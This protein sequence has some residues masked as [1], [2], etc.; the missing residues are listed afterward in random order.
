MISGGEGGVVFEFCGLELLEK[1][2]QEVG[3]ISLFGR[4]GSFL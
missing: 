4:R 1:G 2:D 3:Q